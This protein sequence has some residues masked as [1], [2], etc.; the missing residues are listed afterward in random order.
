MYTLGKSFFL[1]NWLKASHLSTTKGFGWGEG[2]RNELRRFRNLEY[3]PSKKYAA[4]ILD[5]QNKLDE[6]NYDMHS[7]V[8]LGRIYADDGNYELSIETTKA[9]LNGGV[10]NHKAYGALGKAYYMLWEKY[11]DYNHLNQA[12]DAFRKMAQR[13]MSQTQTVCFI[14]L[15]ATEFWFLRK[16]YEVAQ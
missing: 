2:G 1:E 11:C 12:F 5:L 7:K 13:H 3:V 4:R 16:C 15:V 8:E 10:D 6:D 14:W 9:A